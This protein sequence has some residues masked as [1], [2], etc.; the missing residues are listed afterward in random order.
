MPLTFAISIRPNAPRLDDFP[1]VLRAAV[2]RGLERSTE[3]LARA[4]QD[5]IRKPPGRKSQAVASQTLLRSIRSEVREENGRPI[6]R[7][8]PGALLRPYGLYVE[9]GTRPHWPPVQALEP[10]VR[11]KFSLT[12]PAEIRSAAW[13]VARK[14]AREGTEGRFLFQRAAEAN[15]AQVVSLIEE[16][17]R[18]ALR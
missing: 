16:E 14:I 6:G 13:R 11:V 5:N 15:R 7:V 2:R 9:R 18:R 12:R 3:L 10:W 1:A 4:V 8:F 17:I